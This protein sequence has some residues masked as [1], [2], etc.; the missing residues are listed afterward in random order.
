MAFLDGRDGQRSH[1]FPRSGHQQPSV[2]AM[3]EFSETAR[4]YFRRPG[5]RHQTSLITTAG[6]V[7]GLAGAMIPYAKPYIS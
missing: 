3:R 4:P 7:R 6:N 5:S 2:G 1:A